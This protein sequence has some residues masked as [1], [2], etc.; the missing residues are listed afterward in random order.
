MRAALALIAVLLLSGSS[1]AGITIE[2]ANADAQR[3]D[4]ATISVEEEKFRQLARQ[5]FI[6]P[7]SGR[8]DCGAGGPIGGPRRLALVIG[9]DDIKSFQLSNGA[10]DA[11]LI[12]STLCRTGFAVTAHYNRSR[13]ELIDAL[14]EFGARVAQLS[15]NDVVL[16][17]Y[18][19]NGFEIGRM[20]YIA[21]TDSAYPTGATADAALLSWLSL[22]DV[23]DALKTHDGSKIVILDTC[24]TDPLAKDRDNRA[25]SVDFRPPKNMLIAYAT[26]P[27]LEAADA[28][29]A[30]NGP[31]AAA[32]MTALEEPSRPAEE[33]FR[34]VRTLVEDFTRGRQFPFVESGL[35]QEV[36]LGMRQ[37]ALKMRS[38]SPVGRSVATG[39]NR[40]A[41]VIG[42]SNYRAV[43]VLRNPQNDAR[44][45]AAALRRLG[46][47]TVIEAYDLTREE[48][49]LA[50][51]DFSDLSAEADWALVYFAGHG[52]QYDHKAYVLPVDAT[53]QKDSQ[54]DFDGYRVDQILSGVRPRQLGLVI[55]DACRDN[56][57][58]AKMKPVVSR[59]RG[60]QLASGL[61]ELEV[62]EDNILVAYSA[63]HGTKALDGRGDHSPYV[64]ALLGNI[65]KPHL[66]IGMLFRTVR[67]AVRKST[68]G[69][70]Q[71]FTYGSLSSQQM[72]F[73]Q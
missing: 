53:L 28:F 34:R 27:G 15:K 47:S 55:M 30:T 49:R 18:A 13:R 50:L 35:R 36:F 11:A 12:A 29:T 14:A 57:F 59:S 45:L 68:E 6:P 8:E 2:P 20:S 60:I 32:L 70:Q 64:E 42:N 56:P 38:H 43:G 5:K 73:K 4:N 7:A 54:I 17:Y 3:R 72:F 24:R 10:N 71:P 62:E 67:D 31:Y 58:I 63:K 39:Q 46:F 33:L 66:E 61:P 9:N 25:S 41:L 22:G 19:G 16:V 51:R 69:R 44:E 52:I 21:A 1:P 48:L 26:E 37:S 65:E 23:L 40:I